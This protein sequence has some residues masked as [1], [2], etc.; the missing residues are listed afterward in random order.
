M[1]IWVSVV[2]LIGPGPVV[3]RLCFVIAMLEALDS[4]LYNKEQ[5]KRTPSIKTMYFDLFLFIAVRPQELKG[6]HS[7]IKSVCYIDCIFVVDEYP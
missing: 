6:L 5:R 1:H 7:H 2:A 3:D 4:P